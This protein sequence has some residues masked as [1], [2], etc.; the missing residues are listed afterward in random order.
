MLLRRQDSIPL[1][2]WA[3]LPPPACC[4]LH[5]ATHDLGSGK[6]LMLLIHGFPE[7]WACWRN[8][9]QVDAALPAVCR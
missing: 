5:A 4:R 3:R 8:Q 6:P 9:L 2:A 7:T 1:P